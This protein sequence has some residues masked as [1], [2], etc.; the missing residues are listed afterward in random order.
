MNKFGLLMREAD[1][2]IC[3]NYDFDW[4]YIYHMMEEDVDKMSDEARSALHL[5][6]PYFCT[7]GK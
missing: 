5:D 6:L 1:I 7:N 4:Q 2:I 3:H